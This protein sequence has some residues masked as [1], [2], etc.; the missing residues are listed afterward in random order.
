[1][2]RS[3]FGQPRARAVVRWIGPLLST[4]LLLITP[5]VGTSFTPRLGASAG[6][7]ASPPSGGPNLT[8]DP[9]S[10]WM[11]GGTSA[12]VTAAWTG[13]RAGCTVEPEWYRW[14]VGAG[15][16]EGLLLPTN[17]STATFSAVSSESGRTEI[18]VDGAAEV[19]CGRNE[20]AV[21]GHGNA[22][23]RVDA[24]LAVDE[25]RIALPSRGDS[26]EAEVEGTLRGG[27]P[28]FA[29]RLDWGDG[30][31]TN[32]TV[33]ADGNFSVA[34]LPGTDPRG[35]TVVVTDSAGL[36]AHG[37]VEE[38]ST[39]SGNFVV[40]I[41]PSTYTAD[42]DVPVTFQVVASTAGNY[43]TVDVCEDAVSLPAG[44]SPPPA[45]EFT[46]AFASP[47]VANVSVVAVE[48]SFPFATSYAQLLEP[49]VPAFSVRPAS[50]DTPG[51]VGRET[52][53]PIDLYGGVPPFRLAWRFVGNGTE[54]TSIVPGDG[55]FLAPVTPSIAGSEQVDVQGSDALG[56]P[57]SNASA[58]ISVDAPLAAE[59]SAAPLLAHNGTGLTI[60]GAVLAGSPPFAWVVLGGPLP[61]NRSPD[62]G[63]LAA[64][65]SFAWTGIGRA[66]G[67]RSAQVVVVDSAGAVWTANR[68]EEAV[69]PLSLTLTVRTE[70]PGRW[71]GTLGVVGGDP[72]FRV[73]VNGSDGEEWNRS[74]LADGRWN[75]SATARGSGNVTIHLS[76]V[77]RIGVGANVSAS[78]D[79]P[80]VPVTNA[81]LPAIVAGGVVA[82]VVAAGTVAF[83][84]ARRAA[85]T[86]AV[87]PLEP[88]E[89]LRAIIAPADGADRAVVE[90]LAEEQG[91]PIATVRQT[92]DRLIAAGTIRAERGADGEEILAW[93]PLP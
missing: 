42:V 4:A 79:L 36:V 31:L 75:L 27:Q 48:N 5:P 43:S 46:C 2:A 91:I 8:V 49:V 73:Y 72:P 39:R 13:V 76:L 33:E 23:I 44:P 26:R 63:G 82:L 10:W 65:G 9:A 69:P 90:L 7:A 81:D 20:T 18:S 53:V 70:A 38:N 47:G 92:I 52:Y 12:P 71:S 78:L 51:E 89:A 25:L 93:R 56:E 11:T 45:N 59:V 15:G 28:P 58:A 37:T 21:Y 16:S 22:T 60:T 68:S 62:A 50:N 87:P 34:G 85:R 6:T 77:D 29:V 17:R 3:E 19:D 30:T 80:A 32:A 83:R 40:L 24:P 54:A 35:P 1:M 88:T 55:T 57:A 66:E 61:G 74:G 64:D 41:E 67:P 84:R 86:E 14:S